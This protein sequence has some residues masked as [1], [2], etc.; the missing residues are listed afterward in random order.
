MKCLHC[1]WYKR[2]AFLLC[3]IAVKLG[4]CLMF[5]GTMHLG[6]SSVR[7]GMKVSN[8]CSIIALV[9]LCPSCY[10]WRNCYFGRNCYVVEI[11]FCVHWQSVVMLECL[12]WLLNTTLNLMTLFILVLRVSRTVFM[13]ALCNR[14]PLYFC[15]VISVFY[16]SSIFFFFSSPNLSGHR[17]DLYHAS[18]H[19]VALVP[20]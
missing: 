8:R 16:L 17:L 11:W 5:R 2:T 1:I 7:I 10:P 3:C 12:V 18:T 9:F 15:P 13:A 14:G 6:K 20:I 19:G 4:V